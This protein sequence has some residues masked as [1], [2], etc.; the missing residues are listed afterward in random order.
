MGRCTRRA[1]RPRE[2]AHPPRRRAG[3]AAAGA[4]LAPRLL[5]ALGSDRNRFEFAAQIQQLAGIA[6]VTV[7][8]G[9]SYSVH[10]R[11]ACSKFLR[12]TF[13]EFAAQSIPH[14]DWAKAYYEQ[15]K[16]R[17][18][19]HHAAL[20]ALAYKWI[21]IIF[22]CWKD[23][24][25]YNEAIYMQSLRRRGSLLVGA[26]GGVST[27]ATWKTVAGFQKLSENNA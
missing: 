21:R 7:S 24:K 18:S 4:A 9:Q 3:T 12:Q 17:G 19:S 27:S 22:R 25:P 14:S 5:G 23:G 1:A 13:Q 20:R 10:W 6:P 8:S 26:L 11:L 2:G 16:Q 15:Q